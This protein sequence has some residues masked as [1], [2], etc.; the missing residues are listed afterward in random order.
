MNFYIT[1][2][3]SY[4]PLNLQGLDWVFHFTIIERDKPEYISI[5]TT[6]LTNQLLL[7]NDTVDT[8]D[9]TTAELDKL[10]EERDKLIKRVD[11][12]KSKLLDVKPL[13]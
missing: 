6:M 11:K 9:A 8:M 3:L 13:A 2:N 12:Y 7:K 1:S 5:T 4:T 10:Q